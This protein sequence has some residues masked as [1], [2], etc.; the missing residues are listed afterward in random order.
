M[1]AASS[2]AA[3]GDL[4]DPVQS[5]RPYSGLFAR[6]D[7]WAAGKGLSP[8]DVFLKNTYEVLSHVARIRA[9]EQLLFHRA[10]V[11]DASVRE[12]YFGPDLRI[13]VNLG[14]EPFR[15]ERGMRVA[16]LVL[17]PV[18]RATLQVRTELAATERGAGGFGSTGTR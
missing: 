7:G 15:I 17:C 4:H 8:E 16:Q 9:R 12:T 13:V 3:A 1:P 10:L 11:P 2:P 5:A 14:T 6:D 18:A